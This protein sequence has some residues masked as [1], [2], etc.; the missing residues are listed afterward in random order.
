MSLKNTIKKAIDQVL[1]QKFPKSKVAYTIETPSSLTYGDYS[2]NIALMIAKQVNRNPL[3]IAEQLAAS[4]VADKNL[5][6]NIQKIEVAKPGFL[7]FQI[8]PDHFIN[9][10]K[11]IL[12]HKERYGKSTLG[13]GQTIIID[14]SS[15]NVAKKMHVG[16][17]RSTI[18]GQTLCNVL[19]F[20][21]YKV[22][23]DNHVGDWGTQFGV[24]LYQYKKKYGIKIN[25]QLTIEELE[26]DY[27]EFMQQVKEKPE[28][29]ELA[30]SELA[31]LQKKDPTNLRL[32]KLFCNLSRIEFDKIYKKLGIKFDLWLGESFYHAN[33]EK[34]VK[35]ALT[36]K[37]ARVS[38][39]A[40]I[41]PFLDSENEAP[42]VIQKSD[43]AFLYPTT[44]LATIIYR[45][46][47]FRPAKILYVVANQQSLHFEQLFKAS[48]LLNL[49]PRTE[50]K[51]IKFGLVLGPSGKKMSTREG[52]VTDLN[53]LLDKAYDQALEIIKKRNPDLPDNQAHK[54]AETISLG[55][56]KF[57]D[58]SQNRL[59]DI[60]FDW[61]K[62]LTIEKGS[63][64]YLLYTYVRI[65]S[66]L[67]KTEKISQ[68]Q[69]L[70]FKH[71]AEWKLVR[72]LYRYPEIIE[73][74][75]TEC[76]PNYLTAYLSELASDFHLFYETLPIIK[77]DKEEKTSRIAL[78]SAISCILKS[79]LALLGISTTE[80]M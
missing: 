69:D 75:G 7:N 4:L 57:N 63:L 18:I 14:Y 45:V 62:M 77:S 58:L 39:G 34:V 71:D 11:N 73:Q 48:E 12:Q 16:H 47:R 41:I 50:L 33:L 21:G 43:G 54:V 37:I 60:I 68:V 6:K 8:K 29:W 15:P 53:L 19:R 30:K 76:K 23:G 27:V 61:K 42:M 49:A 28:L 38:D 44:D 36:K 74:V 10:I 32:W 55:A 64:A 78:I 2:S 5:K 1:T 46:N 26:K 3:E 13:R 31:L 40:I 70:N 66:I 80:R 17:L 56:V 65:S 51:H 52:E 67:R 24:L 9:E 72:Q 22:I 25:R 59:S 20:Q 79:G 35:M